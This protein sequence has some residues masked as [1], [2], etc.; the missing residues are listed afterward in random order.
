MSLVVLLLVPI[1]VWI[2]ITDFGVPYW[3]TLSN[4]PPAIVL[5][6]GSL[7]L[8]WQATAISRCT[9]KWPRSLRI[10]GTLYGTTST[11]LA[12]M[13]IVFILGVNLIPEKLLA[14][15]AGGCTCSALWSGRSDSSC[16]E[17]FGCK[18]RLTEDMLAHGF[19]NL[20]GGTGQNQ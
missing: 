2:W 10:V 6:A 17:Y 16:I 13:L 3:G 1:F 14:R 20:P 18:L 5:I 7:Y 9:V 19:N 8:L 11:I 4:T 12:W 15:I